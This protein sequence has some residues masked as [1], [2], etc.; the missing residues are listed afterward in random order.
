M[1]LQGT[2]AGGTPQYTFNWNPMGGLVS[3]M[4]SITQVL[5]LTQNTTYFFTVTD[6]R[7]C[8]S[9]DSFLV[10]LNAPLTLDVMGDTTICYGDSILLNATPGGGQGG[11]TFTWE[12]ALELIDNTLEDPQ[13]KALFTDQTFYVELNDGAGCNAFDTLMVFV[14][15]ELFADAGSDQ[16]FCFGESVTLGA[17]T[18]ASGGSAPYNYT[19]GPNIGLN[20][21][22]IANPIVSG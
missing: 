15:D 11:Y 17:L 22:T 12:P 13:T 21:A 14:N 8:T 6:S 5:G 4:D 20:D 1:T 9:V 18:P 16:T 2:F 19:W 3:P 7:S 10:Q